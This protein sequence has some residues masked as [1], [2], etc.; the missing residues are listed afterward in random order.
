MFVHH[1]VTPDLFAV[2][3]FSN[4]LAPFFIHV[5]L[6]TRLVVLQL[7]YENIEGVCV[8]VFVC[9]HRCTTVSVYVVYVVC[10][11]VCVCIPVCIRVCI[12][13]IQ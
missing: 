2:T 8:F 3:Q 7:H 9:E 11:R 5:S 10:R 6:V 12:H 13:I 1:F 4:L